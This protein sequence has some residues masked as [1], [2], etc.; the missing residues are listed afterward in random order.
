MDEIVHLGG[1]DVHEAVDFRLRGGASIAGEGG[2]GA[3]EKDAEVG[4][5]GR[6]HSV[7]VRKNVG[8][9]KYETEGGYALVLI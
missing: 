4:V 1:F 9:E 5:E 3:A 6:E 7:W 2:G 8:G